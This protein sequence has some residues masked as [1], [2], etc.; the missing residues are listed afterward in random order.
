M[1]E[2][3]NI[4]ISSTFELAYRFVTETSEN[5]FLTGKAGSG[6][7]TFLRYLQSNCAKSIVIAAPTGV[8]AI[9]AGGVTLHSLFNLPLR[10]YVPNAMHKKQLLDETHYRKE[11]ALLLRKMQLLIIDEI[12]MVRCDT[13]D[14]IDVLLRSVRRNGTPFGGVQLLF[15]GDMFQLPPV[16][17][18][19]EWKEPAEYYASPFFFDSQVLRERP[20]LLVELDKIYRQSDST[21]VDLLNK[22]R[23]NAMTDDDFRLLHSRHIPDFKPRPDKNFVTLTTHVRQAEEI[24]LKNLAALPTEEFQYRAVIKDNFAPAGYPVE[25]VLV[26]KEKAQVMFVKNDN[27]NRQYFNGKIGVVKSLEKNSVVVES[28]GMTINVG[29]ETWENTRYT[30]NADGRM[31]KEV[32]GTF[33]QYPLRLA[34]AFTIHKSQGLTFEHA[35]LDAAAAF[36]GGQVYVALSR[37]RSLEGLV[38]LSKIPPSAIA[39]DRVIV[40][41]DQT[42]RPK[43]SMADHFIKARR[44]FTQLLLSDIF[45]FDGVGNAVRLLQEKVAEFRDKLSPES[46]AWMAS[47]AEQV[48]HLQRVGKKFTLQIH[49]LLEVEP[50]IEK[51]E[52]L[53]K[54]INDAAQHFYPVFSAQYESFKKHPLITES[55]E[56]A[57]VLDEGVHTMI[58]QL[59][60]LLHMLSYCKTPFT[61]KD[62]LY[63]SINYSE[64]RTSTST[65]AK[66]KS[67]QPEGNHPELYSALRQWRDEILDRL[68]KPIYMVATNKTLHELCHY[69]PLQAD[70][71]IK[72]AGFGP[73]K[74]KGYGEEIIDIIRDYCRRKGLESNIAEAVKG[75]L[76]TADKKVIKESPT[77][78]LSFNLFKEGK[79][80]EE[81]AKE[82]DL[83]VRTI[84]DHLSYFV[85]KGS[86]PIDEVVSKEKQLLIQ[87]M[88]AG[89]ERDDHYLSKLKSQLPRDISY[90]EIKL[91]LADMRK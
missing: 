4:E 37:C 44:G 7:T 85:E 26:L 77:K 19:R 29:R 76:K 51:N 33:T 91:V 9:N 68:N 64:P 12:S 75:N 25:E 22:V 83:T 39:T 13:L 40:E 36:A 79:T 28:D 87:R 54:R 20:P 90:G 23:D 63:H 27:Q 8:A 88:A 86:L 62:F 31:E 46:Q 61:V 89:V 47:V 35:I 55:K 32:M 56:A 57:E 50:E 80:I 58:L 49:E 69:L 2:T 71:L 11:R 17:H 1:D 10:P 14:A 82:R 18:G 5:I 6:K 67:R 38:L 70:D 45:S 60:N 78:D 73:A 48:E 21:F 43:G 65:Y 16:A 42:L 34:W 81:I 84:V 15:V 66:G 74:I 24:N 72:I 59:D 53:R 30:V 41:A 52:N 3:S